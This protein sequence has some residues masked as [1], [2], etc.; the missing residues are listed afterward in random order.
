MRVRTRLT[1]T[2]SSAV[3]ETVDLGRGRFDGVAAGEGRGVMVEKPVHLIGITTVVIH[4][5]RHDGFEDISAGVNTFGMVNRTRKRTYDDA[6][7]GC[8]GQ[9]WEIWGDFLVAGHLTWR[10]VGS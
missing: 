8:V 1:G 7:T 3:V 4:V 5:F 9:T 2:Q 6:V 10:P